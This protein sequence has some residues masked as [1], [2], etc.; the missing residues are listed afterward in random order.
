MH[1]C[2]SPGGSP[3]S[4][5]SGEPPGMHGMR[6]QLQAPAHPAWALL[7]LP[8]LTPVTPLLP[9]LLFDASVVPSGWIRLGGILFALIGMQYLGT[10]LGDAARVAT[11]AAGGPAQGVY[12]A[13]APTPAQGTQQQQ[14]QQALGYARSFYTATVWSRAF[15]VAGGWGMR[16]HE[17]R[18][19]PAGCKLLPLL[20][21]STQ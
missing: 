8:H 6:L 19:R 17:R 12:A 11:Q 5:A 10:G 7:W 4:M 16:A 21:S 18:L 1:M 14:Q 20:P 3:Q 9:G 13:Q 15:L 2:F